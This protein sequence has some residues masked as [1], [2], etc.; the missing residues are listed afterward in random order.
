MIRKILLYLPAPLRKSIRVQQRNVT[1]L[2]R[3]EKRHLV[4]ASGKHADYPAQAT[5]QQRVTKVATLEAKLHNMR[6]A[7]ALLHGLK[8]PVGGILSFWHVVGNPGARQGFRPGRNIVNGQLVEDFGGGL[9]QLSSA[10]YELALQ[11]GMEVPE[12]FAHSTNVYTPETSYTLLGLDATLAYGYKDLRL[13]NNF[14]FSLTFS[15]ELSADK[16]LVA[17]CAPEPL[18]QM[19]LR[20]E[21]ETSEEGLLSSVYRQENGSEELLSRDF[22]KAWTQSVQR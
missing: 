14:S 13:R 21:H 7:I 2:L 22:Y 18:P 8:I 1:D 6:K 17:L 4:P 9:C 3:G 5:V 15:F 10:M 19:A 12:R 20:V 16:L 11:T